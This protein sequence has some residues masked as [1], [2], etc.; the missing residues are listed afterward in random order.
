MHND[1][2]IEKIPLLNSIAKRKGKKY[3][4]QFH[5]QYPCN[6]SQENKL[7]ITRQKSKQAAQEKPAEKNMQRRWTSE[8]GEAKR[9]KKSESRRWLET[10]RVVTR[11]QKTPYLKHLF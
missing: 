9:E 4:S 2:N 7:K 3:Y 5:H 8:I 10:S 6:I 1:K 11:Q